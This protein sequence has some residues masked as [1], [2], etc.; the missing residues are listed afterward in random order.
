[1]QPAVR[2]KGSVAISMME[3]VESGKSAHPPCTEPQYGLPTDGGAGGPSGSAAKPQYGD[4]VGRSC[5]AAPPSCT[6]PQ[7]GLR[8]DGGARGPVARECLKAITLDNFW[9]EADVSELAAEKARWTK[10]PNSSHDTALD[11]SSLANLRGYENQWECD[12]GTFAVS[13]QR[14][15]FN[16]RQAHDGLPMRTLFRGGAAIMPC[17]TGSRSS[18]VSLLC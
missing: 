12:F 4:A 11:A 7:Y 9:V 8:T 5:S 16:L 1:M 18:C 2:S 10:C 17:Y 14:A 13:D 15:V 6:E 3:L